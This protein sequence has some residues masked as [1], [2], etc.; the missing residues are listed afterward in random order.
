MEK[1]HKIEFF[2]TPQGRVMIS[3]A[4]NNDAKELKESDR[5][6]ITQILKIV[7]RQFPE[8]LKALNGI[9]SSSR[10]NKTYYDYL[11]ADRFVR[12]NFATYDGLK[13]D[14]DGRAL[15]LE[16]VSCPIRRECPYNG[17]VCR[18]KR[19]FGLGA[20]EAKILQL[21]CTGQTY[22]EIANNLGISCN[23]IK[24]VIQRCKRKMSL[25]SSKDLA[26]VV[27]SAIL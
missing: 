12:C 17:I 18:P 4:G 5:E 9:Y 16:D 26:K 1:S 6:L 8:A 10:L 21:L 2:I 27:T 7:E 25:Q 14:L 22:K 23:T 11:R 15:H 24:N 20:Q 19:T 13:Y 3:E